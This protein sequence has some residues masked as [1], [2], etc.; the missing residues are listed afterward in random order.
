MPESFG[1]FGGGGGGS[2]GAPS[3]A[4][5]GDLTGTYPNPTLKATGPG[6]TGPIGTATVIPVLTIDAQ[7]RVTALTSISVAVPAGAAPD[8]EQPVG[9]RQR[10]HGSNQPGPGYGSDYG[11]VCV[12]RRWRRDY[13]AGQRDCPVEPAGFQPV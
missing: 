12:R 7:G 9:P 4:A 3:G 10:C 8:G 11:I 1:P 13:G 6:A 2:G 5:G